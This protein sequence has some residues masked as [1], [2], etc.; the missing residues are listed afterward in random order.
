MQEEDNVSREEVAELIEELLL[1]K[2]EMLKEYLAIEIDPQGRLKRLPRLIEG[3]QP[4]LGYLPAFVL[5][6]GRDV[7]W[8]SEQ[9]CFQNLAEVCSIPLATSGRMLKSCC[10]GKE[11]VKGVAQ[12]S[13]SLQTEHCEPLTPI[14][15]A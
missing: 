2:A 6:L 7:D 10:R 1:D 4:D 8:H 5:G 11:C 14:H 3:Y 9:E 15:N 13:K 12:K